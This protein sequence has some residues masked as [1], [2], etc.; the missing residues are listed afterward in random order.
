MRFVIAYVIRVY[1]MVI[2]TR[3]ACSKKEKNRRVAG[4]RRGVRA[5]YIVSRSA[6][7]AARMVVPTIPIRVSPTPAKVELLFYFVYI[8]IVVL[9]VVSPAR[10]AVVVSSSSRGSKKRPCRVRSCGSRDAP[11]SAGTDLKPNKQSIIIIGGAVLPSSGCIVYIKK[12]RRALSW[13]RTTVARGSVS[14][15]LLTFHKLPSV[16]YFSVDSSRTNNLYYNNNTY[17]CLRTI[18]PPPV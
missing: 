17:T 13:G 8:I 1:T 6:K 18:A 16:R 12:Y 3:N 11:R 14:P 9:R 7:Q 4:R 15:D 5:A 10:F 2:I